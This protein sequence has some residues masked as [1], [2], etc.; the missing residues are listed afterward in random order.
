MTE[1]DKMSIKQLKK[2][3]F[4]TAYH[5]RTE[6]AHL[7]SAFS[8]VEVLY[9]LYVKRIMKFKISDPEWRD[10]DRL[11]LSKGHG[12]LAL[13][14]SMALA[15]FFPMETLKK[16]FCHPRSP[17]GGEPHLHDLDGIEAST[18]SLGHGLSIGVGMALASKIDDVKNKVFVIIGDGESQE[19]AIWEAA[20]SAKNFQLDNLTVILDQNK[21]QE[22]GTVEE[23]SGVSDWTE[24][25]K[26]FGWEVIIVDGHDLDELSK[27]LALNNII[28]M[29]RIVIAKTV[30]GKGVPLIEHRSDWHYRMPNK[31]QLKTFQ[32]KLNITD[33]ELE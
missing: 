29:P 24:K 12:V 10:R 6:H 33:S 21:V 13:Y 1:I 5:G 28:N 8:L 3:I 32:D 4:L 30:K 2:D 22:M 31:R 17:Y 11:I 18:G 25:W 26:S 15:G 16:S 19:G 27:V 14:S 9:T 23:V 7:A 20:M